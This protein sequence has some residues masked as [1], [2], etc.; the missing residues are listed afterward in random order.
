[1]TFTFLHP[2]E[3][4]PTLLDSSKQKTRTLK[5]RTNAQSCVLKIAGRHHAALLPG[6][7][8]AQQERE[9]VQKYGDALSAEVVVAP[10]HGS[11]SSSSAEFVQATRARHVVALVGHRNRFQHPDAT[12]QRRWRQGGAMFWRTDKH[13]AVTVYSRRGKL[14]VDAQREVQRRYWHPTH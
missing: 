12:V 9:M 6:D 4:S 11:A 13:G 1:M 2:Q 5:L 10:H 3:S 7:L 8:P 14:V